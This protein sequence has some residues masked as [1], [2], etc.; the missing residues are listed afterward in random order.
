MRVEMHRLRRR[1]RDYYNGEGDART[2]VRIEIPAGRLCALWSFAPARTTRK[3]PVTSAAPGLEAP[4]KVP[5]KSPR[6]RFPRRA[7]SLDRR[8]AAAAGRR[9]WHR[10]SVARGPAK[11]I[12][13][14]L[15]EG[16]S[17]AAPFL[18]RP[19]LPKCVSDAAPPSMDRP[20]GSDLG[21]RRLLPRRGGDRSSGAA[22]VAGASDAHLFESARSGTFS[23][24]VPLRARTY[25]MRLYFIEP[26][27][28]PENDQGGEG[29]RL[30]NV[31]V[32]GR[33]VL[34]RFDIL[35]DADGAVD[36]RRS[37]LQGYLCPRPTARSTSS[38]RASR[39]PPP[40]RHRIR[41]G[42]AAYSEPRPAASAEQL[43]Y[44]FRRQ[45][46]DPDSYSRGGRVAL[47]PGP[48]RNT[49][50]Q[51]IFRHERF[52]RFRYA[53]PPIAVRTRSIFISRRNI[54]AKG[55]P[56]GGGAE[57]AFSASFATARPAYAASISSKKQAS[58]TAWCGRSI[59]SRR[60]PRVNCCSP[61][62]PSRTTPRSTLGG[63]RRGRTGHFRVGGDGDGGAVK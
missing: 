43:L 16:V 4:S 63:D 52:G 32:N 2:C 49:S 18:Q 50:D 61:S 15:T 34:D 31:V 57:R 27:F 29:N 25:E 8:V 9:V 21:P 47:H 3:R 48:V 20:P 12:A 62:S 22:Y 35:A 6:S 53:V 56:G 26:V 19:A 1:L 14:A 33:K 17:T 42:A 13:G 54:G 59:T 24:R 51:E 38:F 11:A 5:P 44:R 46:V 55:N 45:P 58:I 37:R 30:F 60:M 36:R 23:Y 28:G 41:A 10:A 39:A 40:Q 7:A